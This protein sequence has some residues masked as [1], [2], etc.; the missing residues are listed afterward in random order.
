[1]GWESISLRTGPP[2]DRRSA[3]KDLRRENQSCCVTREEID[4][5]AG[6]GHKSKSD[7]AAAIGGTSMKT[8]VRLAVAIVLETAAASTGSAG[9]RGSGSSLSC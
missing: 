2:T 8:T 5:L 6:L 7:S 1:M 4:V 9:V 3:T